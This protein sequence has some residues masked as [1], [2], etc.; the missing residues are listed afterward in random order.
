MFFLFVHQLFIINPSA[1]NSFFVRLL[2]FFLLI[3]A[4]AKLL[5]E[6]LI[7]IRR[8]KKNKIKFTKNKKKQHLI[9]FARRPT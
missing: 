9:D 1:R 5:S 2:I 8:N 6:G 3:K 7:C 4:F